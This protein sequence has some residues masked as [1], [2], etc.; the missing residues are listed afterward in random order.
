LENLLR[1]HGHVF[2]TDAGR[3]STVFFLRE[4][5]AITQDRLR[6]FR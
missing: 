1:G 2:F 3:V 5:A 4:L 6:I